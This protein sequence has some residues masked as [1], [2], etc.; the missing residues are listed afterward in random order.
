MNV[1]IWIIGIIYLL[2]LGSC[3][4]NKGTRLGNILVS[5]KYWDIVESNG[6]AIYCYKFEKKGVCYYYLYYNGVERR[7]FF[8]DDLVV[9]DT[10]R[11]TNDG[12]KIWIRDREREVI[13]YKNDSV[14][15]FNTGDSSNILLVRS[16][17]DNP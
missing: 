9:N 17:R 7:K 15:L 5:G 4:R 13:G 16:K 1:K 12:S 10:W 8:Q 11:I 3:N 14:F 6:K 2:L